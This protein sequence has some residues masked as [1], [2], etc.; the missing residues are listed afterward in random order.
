MEMAC[1]SLEILPILDVGVE[2]R[3]DGIH[4]IHRTRNDSDG[5]LHG[6]VVR[7]LEVM[8]CRRL[9]LFCFFKEV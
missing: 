2:N 5:N 6:L 1:S 4:R 3:S 9:L 8:L 7:H